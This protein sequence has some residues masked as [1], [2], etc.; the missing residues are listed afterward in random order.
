MQIKLCGDSTMANDAYGGAKSSGIIGW[1]DYLGVTLGKQ[2]IDAG[3]TNYAIAGRSA[4]TFTEENRF[5]D[6]AANLTADDVVVM[7]FGW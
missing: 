6:V 2:G 3:V 7:E 5:A 1:G 4:R